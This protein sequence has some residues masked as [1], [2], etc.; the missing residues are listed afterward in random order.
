MSKRPS[1]DPWTVAE[2]M[3]ALEQAAKPGTAAIYRRHGAEGEVW[4]V[5]YA[6]LGKLEKRIRVD[7]ALALALWETGVHDARTLA[8]KVADPEA[9][10]R[11]QLESWLEQAGNRILMGHVGGLIARRADGQDVA[12]AWIDGAG[13]WIRSA[14]WVGISGLANA[15]RLDERVASP[16][17]RRISE[18]IHEA[19]NRERYNMNNALIAIGGG[20][21]SLRDE[22]A[23]VARHVGK[24]QVDHGETG[25]KTPDALPYMK[26]MWARADKARPPRK[27]RGLPAVLLSLA[28]GAAGAG[29][30]FGADPD[31]LQ[32]TAQALA[33]QVVAAP[34]PAALEAL[35]D[36]SVR[37]ALPGA[38]LAEIVAGLFQAHGAA[39]AARVVS[40][41]SPVEGKVHLIHA[42]DSLTPT[43]LTLA[44]EA[45]HGILGIWFGPS[46][47][48]VASWEALEEDLKALPGKAGYLVARLGEGDPTVLHA[49]RGEEPLAIGSAFKLY[50][51]GAIAESQWPWSRVVELEEADCS[52]PSGTLHSWPAGSPLTVH[53]AAT[54]MI[55][56]SDNTATDLLLRRL[57]RDAVEWS[58]ELMG[59]AHAVRN[60][61]FLSTREMFVLKSDAGLRQRYLDADEGERRKLLDGPVAAFPREAIRPYRDGKPLDVETVEWFASPLDLAKALDWLRRKDDGFLLPLMGVNRGLDVPRDAFPVAGYKGGSEPGVVAVSWV[62]RR[63]D[64]TWWALTA[65]W[66]DPTAALEE[67]RFF[68]LVQAA[69]RLLA[70]GG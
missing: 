2:V 62:L 54:A 31:P 22:A 58:V 18:T 33:A 20:I 37:A 6:D 11:R 55:S 48:G 30:G 8:L 39:V 9:F 21:R 5:P 52:L 15:G 45:P 60:R 67:E 47:S 23:A 61:P 63:Q 56:V 7:H 40:Q 57:G 25:C 53:T 17:L 70:K 3:A 42:D 32:V 34:D 43:T 50:V 19:F 35:L 69:I 4:G 12:L 27:P 1:G 44:V 46:E 59:N 66:N 49:L 36:P 65:A 24:V 64:D 13:E 29:P 51:L 26:K 41:D 16:L 68:S 14:G 38:K 28:M 10:T